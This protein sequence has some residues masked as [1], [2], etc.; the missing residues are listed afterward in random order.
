M[1]VSS[2]QGPIANAD[3][4]GTATAV[5]NGAPQ[6][7]TL[8]GGVAFRADNVT[9]G[10]RAQARTG[11]VWSRFA[12]AV[13]SLRIVQYFS[14]MATRAT[15]PAEGTPTDQAQTAPAAGQS[16]QHAIGQD[17]TLRELRTS[18]ARLTVAEAEVASLKQQVATLREQLETA[19]RMQRDTRASS[20]VPDAV[21]PQAEVRT[22]VDGGTQTEVRAFVEGGTQTE[23]DGEVINNAANEVPERQDRVYAEASAQTESGARADEEAGIKAPGSAPAPIASAPPPAPPPPPPGLIPASKVSQNNA[24]RSLEAAL[25][26]ANLK[27]AQA[28]ADPVV[29]H[30]TQLMKALKERLAGG[31]EE[32]PQRVRREL[33]PAPKPAPTEYEKAMAVRRARSVSPSSD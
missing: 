6:A 7:G 2:N 18:Y 28:Q 4:S 29:D 8:P 22:F 26:N 19:Q 9:P 15:R 30:K 11:S 12:D 5:S 3:D 16:E 1:N 13:K 21:A 23:V 17:G 25:K 10:A 14:N 33:S 31:S 20:P 27:A 24:G 32:R